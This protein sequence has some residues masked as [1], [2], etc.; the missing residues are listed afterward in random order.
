MIRLICWFSR[1][2]FDIHDYFVHSGGDGVPTHW[3]V[4][5]CWNCRRE[6][7]V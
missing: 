3:H 6:F 5:R 7:W 4:Y 1:R 2:F